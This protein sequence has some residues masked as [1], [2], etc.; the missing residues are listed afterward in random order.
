[1][2]QLQRENVMALGALLGQEGRALHAQWIAGPRDRHRPIGFR[3]W[4]LHPRLPSVRSCGC[5]NER[6]N[7]RR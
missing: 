1:M 3:I 2:P 4:Q 6:V 5:H 7:R